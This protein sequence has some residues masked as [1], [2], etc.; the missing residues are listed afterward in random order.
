MSSFILLVSR[1]QVRLLCQMCWFRVNFQELI[2]REWKIFLLQISWVRRTIELSCTYYSFW[3]R[4]NSIQLQTVKVVKVN[5][6]KILHN[7]DF[8]GWLHQ[9]WVVFICNQH[10][11]SWFMVTNQTKSLM[12]NGYD[13][14]LPLMFCL[15]SH[16]LLLELE[17]VVRQNLLWKYALNRS[18]VLLQT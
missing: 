8:H 10:F 13:S 17:L 14:K 15:Q 11:I 1:D 5:Y 4:R 2:L 12:L 6:R 16:F 7:R 3:Q 18:A 9:F